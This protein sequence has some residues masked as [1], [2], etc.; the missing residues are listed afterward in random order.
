MRTCV[1]NIKIS[2]SGFSQIHHKL[3]ESVHLREGHYLSFTQDLEIPPS[4][5]IFQSSDEGTFEPIM[6]PKCCCQYP[7]LEIKDPTDPLM[8]HGFIILVGPLL[9]LLQ[10]PHSASLPLTPQPPPYKSNNCTILPK[11]GL[12]HCLAWPDPF[13]TS[14]SVILRLKNSPEKNH[15]TPG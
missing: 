2:P 1:Y 11:R 5:V 14:Y 6:T 13:L 3:W 7:G 4:H 9:S 12:P 8:K 10:Y 15:Q